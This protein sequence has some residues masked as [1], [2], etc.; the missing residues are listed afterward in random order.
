MSDKLEQILKKIHIYMANCRPA[1]HSKEEIVVSKKRMFAMLEELNYAVYEMMEEYEATTASRQRGQLLAERMATDI[2]EDARLRA[3]DVYAASLL[4]TQRAITDMRHT[5]EASMARTQ[6][7]YKALMDNYENKMK[8][9]RNDEE[10][11]ISQLQIMADSKTYLQIIE[12]RKIADELKKELATEDNGEFLKNLAGSQEEEVYKS[13]VEQTS[14]SRS[15]GTAFSE[16]IPFDGEPKEEKEVA[17]IVVTVH[18]TPHVPEGFGSRKKNKKKN[19][20]KSQNRYLKTDEDGNL[21]APPDGAVYQASDFNLDMEYFQFQEEQAAKES[22]KEGAA[23]TAS[24]DGKDAGMAAG[25]ENVKGV[26]PDVDI[27]SWLKKHS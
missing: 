17:P 3:E 1:E 24:E 18:Q 20:G 16:D 5:M 27:M 2:K 11:I 13:S 25:A 26:K 21:V 14:K 19:G 7:E 22:Q 6:A 15:V 12:D 9:L 8:V 10:E 23:G 4:Y